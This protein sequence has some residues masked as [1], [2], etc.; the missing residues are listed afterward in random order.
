MHTWEKK[1]SSVYIA[2]SGE[3]EFLECRDLSL[4]RGLG[5]QSFQDFRVSF[6]TRE[7]WVCTGFYLV[8]CAR[9]S[10]YRHAWGPSQAMVDPSVTPPRRLH[11]GFPLGPIW[12]V[13]KWSGHRPRTPIGL[14][15]AD[16]YAGVVV[17]LEWRFWGF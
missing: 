11:R 7:I 1:R 15:G 6:H 17:T 14:H 8:C 9:H 3:L 10:M 16:G 12:G 5:V 4:R 13:I 2:M